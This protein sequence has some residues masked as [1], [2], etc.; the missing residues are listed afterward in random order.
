M[1][2]AGLCRLLQGF[3]RATPLCFHPAS[4]RR[5]GNHKVPPPGCLSNVPP[6]T[7]DVPPRRAGALHDIALLK[8]AV[9]AAG[10]PTVEL[11]TADTQ[12][13]E[14][15]RLQVPLIICCLSARCC[16]CSSARK[17]SVDHSCC[18]LLPPPTPLLVAAR[19]RCADAPCA[20]PCPPLPQAA[21]W[22][23]TESGTVSSVLK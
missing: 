3:G 16:R 9:E 22:G 5:H 11:A 4:T 6:A 21:G 20:L 15:G 7:T 2:S 8:L 14:G 23:T 1:G 13:V 19:C 12:L 18:R 17:F 10:V